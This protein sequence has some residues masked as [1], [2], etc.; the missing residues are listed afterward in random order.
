MERD[1]FRRKRVAHSCRTHEDEAAAHGAPVAPVALSAERAA[2]ATQAER[3]SVSVALLTATRDVRRHAQR[4]AA[5]DGLRQRRDDEPWISG[6]GQYAAKRIG[7]L[8][9]GC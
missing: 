1:R 6:D 2:H 5:A 9:P 4:G 7:A 3:V 8:A